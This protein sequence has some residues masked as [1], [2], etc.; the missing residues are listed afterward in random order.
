MSHGEICLLDRGAHV[1][2]DRMD[3]DQV[4][5][6]ASVASRLLDEQLPELAGMP[7]TGCPRAGP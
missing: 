4:D 3:Q 2:R 5:I 7:I 6:D 1:S